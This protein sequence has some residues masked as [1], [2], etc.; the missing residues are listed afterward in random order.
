MESG[1][2]GWLIE[3]N[4]I[5]G[6]GINNSNLDGIDIENTS[7]GCTVR[8]NYILGNEGVGVDSYQSSGTST[9]VNNTITNNGFGTGANVETPGVRL[10]GAG[11]TV[12][13]NII[14]AN[15][16]AGVA[17]TGNSTGNRITQNSIYANGRPRPIGTTCCGDRRSDAG[18][19]LLYPE[20]PVNARGR[21]RPVELPVM[22]QFDV[23][24]R[25]I[26]L[27][28]CATGA[29][30]AVFSPTDPSGFERGAYL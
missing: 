13:R 22:H 10:F 7:G 12:D 18:T 20:L 11:N 16:G 9:I 24:R 30:I 19:S 26:T 5:R 15:A 14:N 21:Q 29:V 6:N 4:E 17:V 28:F 8:G 23:R 25:N 1:S 3:N 2:N 27:Y